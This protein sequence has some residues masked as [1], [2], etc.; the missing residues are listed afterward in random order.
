MRQT[1]HDDEDG[2]G[3]QCDGGPVQTSLAES[4]PRLNMC[5]LVAEP[6]LP[7]SGAQG[8]TKFLSGGIKSRV[9]GDSRLMAAMGGWLRAMSLRFVTIGR[10]GLY[11]RQ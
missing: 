9:R 10:H 2:L 4:T 1:V 11:A 5:L 3:S 7:F 8:K 6:F